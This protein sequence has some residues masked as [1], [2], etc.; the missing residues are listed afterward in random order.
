MDF[1]YLSIIA[2]SPIAAA[3][4]ILMMPK[5]RGE[6]SRMLALAAMILGLV[7]SLYT[8][9]AYNQNLPPADARWADTLMF[10][11]EHG[12]ISSIGV[13]YILGIDGLSA[14]L[15]LLT[16]IVGLGACSSP[17]VLTTA[18]VNSMPFS[19]CWW[20]VCRVCLWR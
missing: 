14:T 10:V 15:V 5:E 2:L 17:G 8:Y 11:E 18:R 19:C 12:W 16:S 20:R 9:I 13:N 6:N 7:L 1:P 4:I 3:V